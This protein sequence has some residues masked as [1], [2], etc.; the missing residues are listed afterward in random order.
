M[1][2]L[3]HDVGDS[4][5]GTPEYKVSAVQSSSACDRHAAPARA[6]VRV[7][8]AAARPGRPRGRDRDDGSPDRRARPARPAVGRGAAGR[9][10]SSRCCCGRRRSCRRRSSRSSAGWRRRSPSSTRSS[11]PRRSSGRTTSWSTA[12]RSRACSRRRATASSSLGIG[13]NVNQTRDELPADATVPAGSLRHVDGRV[14][15]REELLA[16]AAGAAGRPLR[17][18][19][20]GRPRRGLRRPRR[21]RLPARPTGHRRRRRAAPRR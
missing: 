14:R 1:N 2:W 17:G 6:G 20:R 10:C 9:R 11:S 7:D 4:L 8:A 5:I 21:A 13:V 12:A 19:A 16:L 15:D 3:T 18:L